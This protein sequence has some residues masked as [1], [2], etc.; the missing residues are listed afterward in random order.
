MIVVYSSRGCRFDSCSDQ[1]DHPLK[2]FLDNYSQI[3]MVKMDQRDHPHE[4][5]SFCC[6]II[7]IIIIISDHHLCA[8]MRKI[9]SL[10]FI[11]DVNNHRKIRNLIAMIL[12]PK[13]VHKNDE[14]Q[15]AFLRAAVSRARDSKTD[16]NS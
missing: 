12:L 15:A 2:Y 16:Q 8:K 4:L 3:L 6:T 5:S 10:D 13:K 1:R 14:S 7:I 11:M 9:E